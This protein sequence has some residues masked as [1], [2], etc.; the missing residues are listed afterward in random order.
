MSGPSLRPAQIV[1]G[2]PMMSLAPTSDIGS[3]PP[4]G[5]NRSGPVSIASDTFFFLSTRSATSSPVGNEAG[6][7]HQQI[8]S[9]RRRHEERL[10]VACPV[11][12]LWR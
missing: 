10:V 8:S 5:R 4:I 3:V 6:L 7:S 1:F 9:P 2:S 12:G 11:L